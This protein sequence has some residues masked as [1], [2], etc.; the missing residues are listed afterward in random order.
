MKDARAFWFSSY[1]A[2]RQNN[3]C[4]MIN[5]VILYVHWI[6]APRAPFE[7]YHADESSHEFSLPSLTSCQNWLLI[8]IS[9]QR[10][11]RPFLRFFGVVNDVVW[12]V[13]KS[14]VNVYI[15]YYGPSIHQRTHP[16]VNRSFNQSINQSISYSLMIYRSVTKNFIYYPAIFLIIVPVYQ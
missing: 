8:L 12:W 11:K 10:C 1:I 15:H 2:F 9:D 7:A 16:P 3:T 13:R 6:S 5:F 14:S 4:Q